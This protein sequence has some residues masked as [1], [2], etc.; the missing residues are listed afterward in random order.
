MFQI[1]QKLNMGLS[2]ILR[3]PLRSARPGQLHCPCGELQFKHGFAVESALLD[4]NRVLRQH[5]IG[6]FYQFIDF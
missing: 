2:F 6:R 3:L 5:A 4:I 1:C